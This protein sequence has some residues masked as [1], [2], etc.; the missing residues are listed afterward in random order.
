M[1]LKMEIVCPYHAGTHTYYLVSA[2]TATLETLQNP[3]AGGK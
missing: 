3:L 2:E 1:I